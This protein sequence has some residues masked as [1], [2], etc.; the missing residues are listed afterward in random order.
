[1]KNAFIAISFFSGVFV[2][3]LFHF[4]VLMALYWKP[5]SPAVLCVIA[6]TIIHVATFA[7]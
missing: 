2:V 6:E 5:N 1:M 7:R 4:E 3:D